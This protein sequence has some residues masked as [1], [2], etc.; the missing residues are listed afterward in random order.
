MVDSIYPQ[1]RN[2]EVVD[3]RQWVQPLFMVY[4]IA[5][6]EKTPLTQ[7][8]L[9]QLLALE[10]HYGQ[11]MNYIKGAHKGFVSIIGGK[12]QKWADDR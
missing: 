5:T 1:R 10:R 2:E 4:D 12:P 6:E 11:L 9:D 7:E 8:R 3:G